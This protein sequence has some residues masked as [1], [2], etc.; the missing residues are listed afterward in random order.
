VRSAPDGPVEPHGLPDD[1]VDTL[2]FC[3]KSFSN[4]AL[5][6]SGGADSLCLLIL[7]DEWRRRN[8]WPG[9]A[10]ILCVDHGL[11]P[12][13]ALEAE[14]VAKAAAARGLS[15]RL[16]RWAGDKPG[17]NVQEEAR[18]ARY[19]LMAGRM[20]ESGAEVL[21]LAH[22]LDDQAETFLDRLTRGSGVSGLSAMAADE[23][24]GPSGLRLLRPLLEVPKQQLEATLS[25]RRVDWCS[26][27]SNN[28]PK[29][30]RSRLR[31]LM[32][33]L[34]GE[35]LSAERIAR[36]ARNIRRA[37]EA[38]DATARDLAARHVEEHEAGPLRLDRNVYRAI[39]EEFRLRLLT[40]LA[41]RATGVPPRLRLEKL[42]ALDQRLMSGGKGRHTLAGALFEMGS[43]TI[44]CWRE[45]GR[46][47][48]ETISHL[49]GTGLWD[50]R[51]RYHV[52][53]GD[54]QSASTGSLTLGPLSASPASPGQI[55]WPQGW[56]RVAF[57]CAPAI[58]AEDELVLSTF[59]HVRS[60][61]GD[62]FRGKGLELVRLPAAGKLMA[63][64]LEDRYDAGEI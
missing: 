49:R 63:N 48:P 51:F 10:E 15:F 22:H 25:A 29:Y 1:R 17:S 18:R 32:A 45:P 59:V 5:A 42:E 38:L 3:L 24:D 21:V 6:V 11:R 12:E 54:D 62:I 34:A 56:P 16:L 41:S 60:A 61:V 52:P 40:Y 53:E 57:D 55:D 27:P 9:T 47:P 36:T 58:W 33:L 13:S 37:R 44:W 2:F 50:N 20:R 31:A 64:L 23:P 4:L 28:D 14:F 39:A 26:D 7:F 8:R 35:G 19:R 43:D 30:K 46:I